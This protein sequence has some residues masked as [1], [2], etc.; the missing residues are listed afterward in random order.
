MALATLSTLKRQ[1][2]DLC[3]V[4]GWL[5]VRDFVNAAFG[6]TQAT[7]VINGPSG[8]IPEMC[9]KEPGKHARCA[10]GAAAT[11]VGFSVIVEA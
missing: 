6:T 4:T 5:R 8:P 9:G 11:P 3:G 2:G 1:L 7:N 10:I